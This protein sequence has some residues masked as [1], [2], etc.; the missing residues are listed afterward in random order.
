MTYTEF[1]VF[2]WP[3]L[4]IIFQWLM[5]FLILQGWKR[6]IN[7]NKDF[8]DLNDK[9]FKLLDDIVSKIE[10]TKV[11]QDAKDKTPV[12]DSSI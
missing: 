1:S 3:W 2:V 8:I 10:V 9:L 6:S 12:Q 4:I 11:K 7:L 5:I